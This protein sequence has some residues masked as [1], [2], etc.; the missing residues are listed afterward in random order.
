VANWLERVLRETACD[1]GTFASAVTAR[2]LNRLEFDNTIRDLLGLELQFSEKF[3]TDGGGG[4]GFNNNGETLYLPV[5]LLERYLEAAQQILDEAVIQPPFQASFGPKEIFRM[6]GQGTAKPQ[7]RIAKGEEVSAST[8]IYVSGEYTLRVSVR[9]TSQKETPLVLKVDGIAAH[10]FSASMEAARP[11]EVVLHLTRGVHNVSVRCNGGQAEI[12]QLELAE[13]Q[14]PPDDSRRLAHQR[15]FGSVTAAEIA[16]LSSAKR[17]ET[18]RTLLRDFT[19]RAFRRPVQPEELDRLLSMY[20]R[21]DRRGDP[22]EESIKLALKTV[23]VSP[24]FLFRVEQEH[25]EPGIFPVTDHEL[26][27]RLSYF[28]WNSMP[29]A[30]LMRLADAGELNRPEVLTRQMERLLAD[31]KS[32]SFVED[33]TGQ[34]LGTRE[35]G[36]SVAFT[37]SAFKGIYTSELAADLREE[38]VQFMAHVIAQNRSLLE[39]IDC[40]YAFLTERTAR[41]YGLSEVTGREFR[42]VS[43]TSGQRGGLLGMGAMHM[44][45]AFPER[46]S[47]VLRGAWVLDTV[48]GTPVPPPPPGVPPLEATAKKAK[49]ASQ[50]EQLEQHRANPT[51]AACH[52]VI[53]PIGF[54]L[55]NFD[56]LGR[57]RDQDTKSKKPIDAS[58]V[59]ASGEKFESFADLKKILLQR[60]AEFTRQVTSKMLGYALGRSLEDRD[61]CTIESISQELERS[62]YQSQALIRAIILS[63][64][65]RNRQGGEPVTKSGAPK[66]K[67][68]TVPSANAVRRTDNKVK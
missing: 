63:T 49:G 1:Q 9:A 55:E 6:T 26:A 56:V 59:M 10:Q 29:D 3:P 11:A 66:K 41:H 40:D 48:L 16:A 27:A 32:R 38:P 31:S 28:L 37:G 19:R 18:A 30:E 53:D 23:L 64:P 36:A 51:C 52:D 8:G 12:S 58:G 35:I 13:N 42:R 54:G 22:F 46:T 20:D 14:R 68:L 21:G 50:R 61:D 47:P 7:S 33:F 45:T 57:W 5:I 67:P 44:L 39:L 24:Q 2:R 17:R 65:F 34:W 25:E 43:V 62:G 60:K 15:I 4:E